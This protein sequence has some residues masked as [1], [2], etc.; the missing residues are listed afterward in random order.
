MFREALSLLRPGL[1]RALCLVVVTFAFVQ[2]PAH[3][4]GAH[5]DP[6]YL[7]QTVL[8]ILRFPPAGVSGQLTAAD[9]TYITSELIAASDFLWTSSRQ[10]LRVDFQVVKILKSVVA[11]DYRDYGTSGSAAKY[12]ASVSQLLASRRINPAQYA[13]V[14]MIYRPTNAPPNLF[15]NTWVWYNDEISS[16]KGNPGFSS[17]IYSGTSS[18]VPLS[19]LVVHEYLHQLDHRFEKEAA[20]PD[21]AQHGFINPDDKTNPSGQ[22]LASLLGT[23]FATNPAFYAAMLKYYVGPLN[24]LHL[25]NYRWLDGIRGV[26]R[27]AE[28]KTSYDFSQPDDA[29]VHVSGDDI[30]SPDSTNPG[31]FRFRAASAHSAAFGT[32]TGSGLYLLRQIAFNYEIAA[33]D[34]SFQ[35]HLIHYD[36]MGNPVD[37]RIDD[38]IYKLGRHMLA[39]NRKVI[40][41]PT[42]VEVEDFQ[43]VF[44]KGNNLSGIP[45]LDDWVLLSKLIV[46]ASRAP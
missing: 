44:Q 3:A 29:L 21:S 23:T 20:N 12:S 38:G 34:Y 11:S 35:V 4:D 8:V 25:V 46:D 27:D 16:H 15:N 18:S 36:Q 17:V 45:A 6:G 10:S 41:F 28:L 14:M 24:T 39:T 40:T 22:Q 43:I 37:Q 32:Q 2:H 1:L 31:S 5:P 9:E 7:Q 33:G 19:E 26:F 30:S 42:P 13:G